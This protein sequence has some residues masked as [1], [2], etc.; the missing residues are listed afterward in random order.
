MENYD[1]YMNLI[2]VFAGVY[3]FYV[4]YIQTAK[5]KLVKKSFFIPSNANETNCSNLNGYIQESSSKIMRL[6][7]ASVLF[8]AFD[9]FACKTGIILPTIQYIAIGLYVVLLFYYSNVFRRVNVKYW[10]SI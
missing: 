6:G 2:V 7:W 1:F 9:M 5:G 10:P 8:A 3:C 4:W